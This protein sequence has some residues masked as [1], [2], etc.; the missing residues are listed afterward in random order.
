MEKGFSKFSINFRLLTTLIIKV[1]LK[2]LFSLSTPFPYFKTW[3]MKLFLKSNFRLM[4]PLEFI[5]LSREKKR[6]GQQRSNEHLISC[7]Y[8]G[9]YHHS[10]DDS[11]CG[12]SCLIWNSVCIHERAWI[13][14][15]FIQDLHSF[16]F[17]IV[18]YISWCGFALKQF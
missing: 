17:V 2:C 3:K 4:N 18:Q 9:S 11:V 7:S 12:F 15:V 16:S 14:Y 1:T 6:E 5:E 10:L 8:P 13:N